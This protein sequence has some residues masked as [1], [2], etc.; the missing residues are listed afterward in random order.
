MKKITGSIILVLICLFA[1][2]CNEKDSFKAD[3]EKVS[4]PDM[5]VSILESS[6]SNLLAWFEEIYTFELDTMRIKT[7]QLTEEDVKSVKAHLSQIF[8]SEEAQLLMDGFYTFDQE[9]QHYYVPDGDWF[10]YSSSWLSSQIILTERTNQNVSLVLDGMDIN[11]NKQTIQFDFSIHQGTML[12]EKRS[13][14][15]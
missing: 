8:G 5:S 2:G 9:T 11:E 7:S 14:L 6:E 12:L 4:V 1:A 13:Y 15:T 10:S 3:L